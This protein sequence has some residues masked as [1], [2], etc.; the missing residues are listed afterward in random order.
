MAILKRRLNRKSATGFDVM[1][2]ETESSIVLRSGATDGATVESS[3][4][5]LEANT[6]PTNMPTAAT[7]AQVGPNATVTVVSGVTTKDNGHVDKVT[8]QKVVIPAAPANMKGASASAAGS[9]GYVPAPAVGANSKFLRGDGTWSDEFT[10]PVK[11]PTAAAGTNTSQAAST[12]FVQAAVNALLSAKDA[13]VFKGTLAIGAELPAANCGDV[14]RVVA[15]AS[16][17]TSG[18]ITGITVH[19]ND[20]L[21][22]LKDNTAAKATADW[23]VTHVNHD[24]EVMGP[25]S[26]IDKHVAIF[27]GT[28]GKLIKDSGLTIGTS[29]PANAKFTDTTYNDMAGATAAKAGTHGLVPAPAAGSQSYFL[30]GDGTWVAPPDTK[31]THPSDGKNTGSFGPTANA[32]LAHHGTFV[33]PYLTVNSAGHVTAIVNRTMTMPGPAVSYAATQPTD[34]VEGDL[35]YEPLND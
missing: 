15:N 31:Y 20:T 24:G 30:R 22:C 17:A 19:E 3:L 29:V 10:A 23:I 12:A 14:Y 28:T 16:G 11:V 8:T 13:F 32:T 27:D 34:Q 25:S 33:V 9:A 35:W 4:V 1:H 5:K 2:L 6:H 18:T 21:T 26:A 7:A